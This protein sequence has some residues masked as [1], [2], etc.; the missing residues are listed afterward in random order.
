[1]TAYPHRLPPV[2]PVPGRSVPTGR[3]LGADG[4]VILIT[5]MLGGCWPTASAV[6][7]PEPPA[8]DPDVD[9]VSKDQLRHFDIVTV[10]PQRIRVYKIVVGQISCNED[11][12]THVQTP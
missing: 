3:R 8:K 11:A 2:R 5:I 1:M 7:P 12:S 9:R 10:S 4:L 6:T